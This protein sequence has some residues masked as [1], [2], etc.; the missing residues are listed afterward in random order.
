MIRRSFRRSIRWRLVASSVLLSLITVAVAG[1]LAQSLVSRAVEA[2]VADDLRANAE[3]IAAQ[4]VPLMWREDGVDPSRPVLQ[5]LAWTSSFLA[6]ARVTIVDPLGDVVVDSGPHDGGQEFVVMAADPSD[7]SRRSVEEVHKRIIMFAG[8]RDDEL[9]ESQVARPQGG[10]LDILHGGA[11]RVRRFGGAWDHRLDFGTG[12]L[13]IGGEITDGLT[14]PGME[15][16]AAI[17]IEAIE[18]VEA[19]EAL[20]SIESLEIDSEATVMA[21]VF[22]E[23][24]HRLNISLLFHNAPVEAIGVNV[25]IGA[26][27]A[28]LGFV[29]LTG[30]EAARENALATTRRAFGGAA[31]FASLL[32][33]GLGLVLGHGMSARLRSLTRTAGLMS[34]GDLGARAEVRGED[35][36]GELALRFNDMADRLETNFKALGEERDTLRHFIADASHELRTPIT[37]LR[38]FNELLAGAASDD[39]EAR[40]EFVAESAA[41]IE[42][43]AWITG[44]LLDLS[45][46]EAGLIEVESQ[47]VDVG[48]LLNAAA[49]PHRPTAD[50]ANVTLEVRGPVE[51]L[52]IIGDS[53]RLELALS[54]LIDNALK[55]GAGEDGLIIVDCESRIADRSDV[56]RRL[57]DRDH[58][59]I[60]ERSVELRVSDSGPGVPPAER[61]R[62]F[63]RFE[64]GRSAAQT[65]GSGLGLAIVRSIARAH[66]GDVRVEAAD[67]GGSR[68]VIALGPVERSRPL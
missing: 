35:E 68:F 64:R 30:G 10:P 46:L 2:R 15:H 48:D 17:R 40:A 8:G 5:E 62:I 21:N 24:G 60:E 6:D 50:A 26:V 63:E 67:G 38:S 42:R 1:V 47:P 31:L 55:H 4:A 3:A 49:A 51:P 58:A 44:Q 12:G 59:G 22:H 9:T 11:I 36:I 34:G 14:L 65:D 29:R 61:E 20:E 33:A 16:G 41:Q 32:A 57:A 53:A 19:I 28:P 37:A 56:A 23:D 43:L 66:G 39:V 7:D 27:E 25:P 18:G 13:E 54:N 45:R 52:T